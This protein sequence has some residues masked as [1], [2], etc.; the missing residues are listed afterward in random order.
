MHDQS[1]SGKN[2]IYHPN[3]LNSLSL[4]LGDNSYKVVKY[5]QKNHFKATETTKKIFQVKNR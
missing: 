2:Y 1:H 4:S 3:L 5:E